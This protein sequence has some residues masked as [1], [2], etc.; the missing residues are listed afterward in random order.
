MK[1]A[2]SLTR[3]MKILQRYV[4]T[5][6]DTDGHLWQLKPGRWDGP[7]V[8]CVVEKGS[9]MQCI[10][11]GQTAK[12]VK[13]FLKVIDALPVDHSL[14]TH[15]QEDYEDEQDKLLLVKGSLTVSLVTYDVKALTRS[16]LLKLKA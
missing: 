14:W 6:K 13:K 3:E 10:A 7:P 2:K 4:V 8:Q 5:V 15:S 9:P 12:E 16:D 11:R 1:Q